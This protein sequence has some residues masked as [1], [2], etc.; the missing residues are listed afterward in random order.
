MVKKSTRGGK[1][2]N[3]GRKK[4]PAGEKRIAQSIYFDPETLAHLMVRQGEMT[5]VLGRK[6]S[7]SEVVESIVRSDLGLRPLKPEDMEVVDEAGA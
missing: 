3:S 1:R 5:G 4:K 6:A 7:L 2:D